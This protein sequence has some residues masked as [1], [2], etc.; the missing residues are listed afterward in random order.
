MSVVNAPVRLTG[1]FYDAGDNLIDPSAV[2]VVITAPDGSLPTPPSDS[3]GLDPV[4]ATP[5]YTPDPDRAVPVVFSSAQGRMPRRHRP[6]C[7]PI[8]ALTTTAFDLARGRESCT[9]EISRQSAKTDGQLLAFHPIRHR[10]SSTPAQCGY[11]TPTTVVETVNM[12]LDVSGRRVLLPSQTPV[13]SVQ[14]IT[15][16]MQNIPTI[17]ITTLQIN[18][19]SGIVCTSV[20]GGH[21]VGNPARHLH[22]R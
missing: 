16:R 3:G 4:L 8:S 20:T 13:L 10:R 11:T 7:S 9:C 12:T 1:R 21:A 17:D 6:T 19:V 15:P 2:T 18:P 5:S 14:S 22:S